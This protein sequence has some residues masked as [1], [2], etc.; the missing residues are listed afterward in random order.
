VYYKKNDNELCL[1]S[2]VYQKEKV[3]FKTNNRIDGFIVAKNGDIII[4][5]REVATYIIRPTESDLGYGCKSINVLFASEYENEKTFYMKLLD[6]QKTVL[7][8]T[9]IIDEESRFP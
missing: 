2:K 7:M 9:G 6:D 5:E 3:M 1:Y 8:L 4:A